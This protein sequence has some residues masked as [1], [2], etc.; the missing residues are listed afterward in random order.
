[1]DMPVA[2]NHKFLPQILRAVDISFADDFNDPVSYTF[3]H[4]KHEMA[5]TTPKSLVARHANLP[6]NRF[7]G[8]NTQ[9]VFLQNHSGV[10]LFAERTP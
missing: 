2:A 8:S 5:C 1:M 6:L 4:G 9:A 3:L 10:I 7:P